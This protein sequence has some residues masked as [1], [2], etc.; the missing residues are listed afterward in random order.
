MNTDLPKNGLP[1]ENH[2]ENES[3]NIHDADTNK[4]NNKLCKRCVLNSIKQISIWTYFL[5]GLV[6]LLIGIYFE[7]VCHLLGFFISELGIAA[8]VAVIIGVSIEEKHKN[9][10]SDFA[11]Q[12]IDEI[13]NNIFYSLFGW[14]VPDKYIDMVKDQI[15]KKDFIRHYLDIEYRIKNIEDYPE[16]ENIKDLNVNDLVFFEIFVKFDIENIR[17]EPSEY[18]LVTYSEKDKCPCCNYLKYVFVEA[19]GQITEYHK[20]DLDRKRQNLKE[21][22]HYPISKM[23]LPG[24]PWV[25]PVRNWPGRGLDRHRRSR[26]LS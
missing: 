8:I 18:Q 5:I 12:M 2:S 19:N 14:R 16:L 3:L 6:L 22:W 23:V 1:K 24:F 9:E 4:E 10:F 25:T 11:K 13:R 7:G 21:F 17:S 26:W 20:P 15:M